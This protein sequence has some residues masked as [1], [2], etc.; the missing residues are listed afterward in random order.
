MIMCKLRLRFSVIWLL[1]LCV[2]SEA[3]GQSDINFTSL[4]VR[5]GLSSNTVNAILKDKYGLLWFATMDGLD[6]FDGSGFTAY[7][8]QSNN[9]NSLSTNEVL[10]LYEDRSGNIWIGTGGGGVVM[11]DRKSDQFKHYTGDGSWPAMKTITARCFL[12]DHLGRLWIGTYDDLRIIDPVTG[13]ITIPPIK[14]YDKKYSVSL[15]ILSLFEDSQKRI[16][17]GTNQGL[18]LYDWKTNRFQSFISDPTNQSSISN[19]IIK[20]ITEDKYGN[21]WLGTLGL[22]G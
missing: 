7:R 17:V 14:K 18:Y 3:K 9:P 5:D 21:L 22:S 20:S 15:V 10:S 2:T 6:K 16:W 8:H 12:Q 11:Y 19:D 4:T 1:I 13:H